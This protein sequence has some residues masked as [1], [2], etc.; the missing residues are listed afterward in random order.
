MD[1]LH[2]ESRTS[3]R[4][5]EGLIT[6]RVELTGFHT[7]SLN[8]LNLF[9]IFCCLINNSWIGMYNLYICI[10]VRV[11]VN[12]ANSVIRILDNTV[13]L[14]THTIVRAETALNV[15]ERSR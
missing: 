7:D 9:S 5:M 8:H 12:I 15:I 6:A 3:P 14:C 4:N 10:M 13:V 1:I 11:D 2:L